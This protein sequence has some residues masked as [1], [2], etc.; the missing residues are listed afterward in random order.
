M[1]KVVFGIITTKRKLK[2][3]GLLQDDNHEEVKSPKMSLTIEIQII[4]SRY[5]LKTLCCQPIPISLRGLVAQVIQGGEGNYEKGR[6]W[7]HHN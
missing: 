3:A 1:R 4:I 2:K 6:A 7:H 5:N